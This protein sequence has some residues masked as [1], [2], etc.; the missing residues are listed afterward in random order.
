MLYMLKEFNIVFICDDSGSMTTQ[1]KY[2]DVNGVLNTTT[3]WN[4]A[5]EFILNILDYA[6]A[7][8]EDGIDLFFLNRPPLFNVNDKN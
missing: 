6:I 2:I 1:N 8:D 3:R 4:E 7:L 5:Q